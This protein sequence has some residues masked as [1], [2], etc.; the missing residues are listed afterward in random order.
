MHRSLFFFPLVYAR[1]HTHTVLHN[2]RQIGEGVDLWTLG[3]CWT[4]IGHT[5]HRLD[6]GASLDNGRIVDGGHKSMEPLNQ[7]WLL[8]FLLLLFFCTTKHN[9][10]A[11]CVALFW[12]VLVGDWWWQWGSTKY[13]AAVVG[14]A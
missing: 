7:C 14:S 6:G 3:H 2:S 5:E 8:R 1:K 9:L 11:V 10:A 13:N 4:K 12:V